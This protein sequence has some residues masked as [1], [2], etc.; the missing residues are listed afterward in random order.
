MR[1]TEKDKV[2]TLCICS[3]HTAVCFLIFS[4]TFVIADKRN[5]SDLDLSTLNSL[6]RINSFKIKLIKGVKLNIDEVLMN[7]PCPVINFMYDRCFFFPL[8][9]ETYKS[10]RPGDIVLAKVVSFDHVIAPELLL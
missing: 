3:C 4:D 7:T 1:A 5:I 2:R 8:Q 10:F 6:H 9:V